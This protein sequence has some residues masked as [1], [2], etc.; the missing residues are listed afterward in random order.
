MKKDKEKLIHRVNRMEGQIRGIK[1]MIENDTYCID[2]ITQTSALRGAVSALEDVLLEDHLSC[3]VVDQVKKGQTG[4]IK[5]E[6]LKV[7]KLAKKK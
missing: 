3:C 2:V 7:Y 4:K 1:E 5:E 6:V